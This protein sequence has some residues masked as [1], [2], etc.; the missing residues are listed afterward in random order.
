M[1]SPAYDTTVDQCVWRPVTQPRVA[2][3]HVDGTRVVDIDCMNNDVFCSGLGASAAL[4][5][6]DGI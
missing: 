5:V 2:Q 4:I 6:T 1:F 3:K